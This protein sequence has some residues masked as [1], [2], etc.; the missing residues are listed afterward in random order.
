MPRQ[1]YFCRGINVTFM[2]QMNRHRF[3]YATRPEY[4][5]FIQLSDAVCATLPQCT[6]LAY[7]WQASSSLYNW[8]NGLMIAPVNV[9]HNKDKRMPSNAY[10]PKLEFRGKL[11]ID[12]FMHG[13][14]I[15][16]PFAH[17]YYA[18][19]LECVSVQLITYQFHMRIFRCV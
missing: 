10:D 3:I 17:F 2:T 14:E 16:V 8:M 7:V 9:A 1:K 6:L 4:D 18:Y 12:V 15:P 19:I 13:P 5:H 11:Y